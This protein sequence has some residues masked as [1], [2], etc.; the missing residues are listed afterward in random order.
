MMR[1]F[2]SED[3]ETKAQIAFATILKKL[4]TSDSK[5]SWVY[6]LKNLVILDR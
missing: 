1:T 2:C 3:T 4:L 6:I 5:Q